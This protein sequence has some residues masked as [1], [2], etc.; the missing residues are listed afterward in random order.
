VLDIHAPG[1]AA[2]AR[3]KRWW[4]ADIT[5]MRRSFAGARRA[6]KGGRTSFDEYR[7]VRNDY[8]CH[9]RKAK[10]LAWEHFLEGVF[11]TDDHSELASDPERCWRALRYTKPQVPSH[12]PAIK[13][14]GMDGRPDKIVATAEEKEEIFIA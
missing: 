9:I 6:Y 5:Q 10:R 14:S 7:R 12:T 4:T 13:A 3:S 1:K 8:Y 11:P 2:C